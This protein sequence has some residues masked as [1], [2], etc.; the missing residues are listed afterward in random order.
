MM[1]EMALGVFVRL[2]L[3]KMGLDGYASEDEVKQVAGVLV[4]A[5][6]TAWSLYQKWRV[7]QAQARN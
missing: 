3:V 1:W 7:A 4:V 6:V 5:V 2:A